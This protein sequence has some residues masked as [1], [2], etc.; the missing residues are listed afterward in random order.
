MDIF[1]HRRTQKEIIHTLVPAMAQSISLQSEGGRIPGFGPLLNIFFLRPH[2]AN[3][4]LKR[5][6]NPGI[7]TLLRDCH[8]LAISYTFTDYSL[9]ILYFYF[10]KKTIITRILT[11]YLPIQEERGTATRRSTGRNSNIHG[12]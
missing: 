8:F 3:N 6:P 11:I 7:L 10:L 1:S 12:N 9:Y 4:F 5:G 2:F